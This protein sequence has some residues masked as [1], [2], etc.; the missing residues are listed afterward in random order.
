MV[1]IVAEIPASEFPDSLTRLLPG[2][3]RSAGARYRLTIEEIQPDDS[4]FPLPRHAPAL[5]GVAAGI[6]DAEAGRVVSEEALFARL[7]GKHPTPSA[8]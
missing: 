7:F 5:D 3:I 6:A 4:P 1:R 8:G 2:G